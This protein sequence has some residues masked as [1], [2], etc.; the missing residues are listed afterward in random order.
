MCGVFIQYMW[1]IYVHTRGVHIHEVSVYVWCIYTIHVVY[2][3]MYT[4]IE[5][6][7]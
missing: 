6:S 1:C 3:H 5:V 7:V 4:V 2:I